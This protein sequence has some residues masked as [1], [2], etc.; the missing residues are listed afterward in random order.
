MTAIAIDVKNLSKFYKSPAGIVQALDHVSFQVSQ[1]SVY[2]ILGPNGAGKTTLLRIL[3][4][5]TRPNQGTALIEG[6][7]IQTQA[8][9]VRQQIGIVAQENHFDKYLS[10]WHNLTLHAQ[11]HGMTKAEFEPRITDLLKRVNLYHRRFDY[12]EQFSGGMQRRVALIRALIHSPKVLF[13]DEPT[14]G[15]DPEARREIWEII[16]QCK[17]STTVILTTH[18][19]EEA[20]TLSD[21]ILILNHGRVVMTGTPTA[22]KRAISPE[23]IYLLKL[24]GPKAAG[25]FEKLQGLGVTHMEKVAE[26]TLR[27]RLQDAQQLKQVITAVDLQ[28]LL[29]IGAAEANLEAVYLSVASEKH[30]MG[31]S[32]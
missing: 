29:Q 32:P 7:D 13:L 10:V 25:Y 26:D 24:K 8:L 20:D 6:Y 1:G 9:E 14:T 12:A 11:M 15:L 22:L 23:D 27:F 4:T 17:A 18:Y 3:T 28:D 16:R 31:V 19:M 5:M 2:S 30:P 21:D